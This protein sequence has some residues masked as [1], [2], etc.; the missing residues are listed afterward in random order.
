M[1]EDFKRT[2]DAASR[3]SFQLMLAKAAF[4]QASGYNDSVQED[5]SYMR[6]TAYGLLSHIKAADFGF[7]RNTARIE[8]LKLFLFSQLDQSFVR[9][10]ADYRKP[11]MVGLAAHALIT[12]YEEVGADSQIVERVRIAADYMWNHMWRASGQGFIYTD[13]P[14]GDQG[15]E[16]SPDLNM[17]I[18]PM[19][20]W[21]Y[22]M[23]GDAKYIQQ[24][25]QIWK[26]GGR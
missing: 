3:N 24:G 19:Y 12:Y 10:T 6:E 14:T 15:Q 13:D 23:T 5:W 26:G 22:R 16:I 7:G 9:F 2:G 11:F 8:Q 21:L 20:A 1:A 17:L 18:A 4:S 25:D